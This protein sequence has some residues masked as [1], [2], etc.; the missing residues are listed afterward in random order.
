MNIKI[1]NLCNLCNDTNFI[2]KPNAGATAFLGEFP[3]A[4][5]QKLFREGNDLATLALTLVQC[6]PHSAPWSA[7]SLLS[8]V[9]FPV[10]W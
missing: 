7:Q 1:C 6:V 5:I 2:R 8:I 3:G 10:A 4:S 9:K